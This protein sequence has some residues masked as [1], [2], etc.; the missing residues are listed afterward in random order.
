MNEATHAFYDHD[1]DFRR[2]MHSRWAY[3]VLVRRFHAGNGRTRAKVA[4]FEKRK[5]I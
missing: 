3:D 5:K 2:K 1:Y 4:C